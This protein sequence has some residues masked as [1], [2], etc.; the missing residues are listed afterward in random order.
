MPSI[1]PPAA[2]PGILQ[3]GTARPRATRRGWGAALGTLALLAPDAARAQR[4]CADLMAL[5]RPDLRITRS[6]ALPAGTLPAENPGRAALTG[7]ARS[8]AALPA[9]CVVEGMIAPRTAADG[10]FFGI[11]FQ[12]RLPEAWNGRFLF[13]GGGGMDGVVSEAIGAIPVAGATGVPALNRGYAVV[14][15]DSGHQGRDASDAS[16]G[17]DQ[18]A[19]LDHAG[20]SIGPV[21][22]EA[23]ALIAARYG[24]GPDHAYFMGCSNGGRSAMMAAQRFPLEFDG[25]VA[26]NPGFRLSR[27]AIAQAWDVKALTAAAPRNEA[28]QPVLAA[29]LTPA[30]MTLLAEGIA[31]ACDA[32]DGLADGTVEAMSACRFDPATLRCPG[33]KAA[34]CLSDPQLRALERVFGGA[35]DSQ[36]RPLYAGWPWDPGIA[37]PG[38]RAWKLGT[39]TGGTPNARNAT[40][41]AASLGLYFMTPPVDGLDLRSFDFDRDPPRTAQTAAINDATATFLNSFS[42]H[43]GRLLVFHGQA[44]PVF[45]A[46]DLR[47][48]WAELARD[49]GGA[50]ALSAWARLFVVPGMNHCGGGPA[51]DDFDPLAAIEA[52]VERGQAPDRLLARGSAFPG[53][54][55]PLCPAPQEARYRGGDPQEAASF[56]CEAPAAP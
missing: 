37:A 30:D 48:H 29:A 32:A 56:A 6:E 3:P 28:G 27:A 55:R 42:G 35:R 18:Q 15:T 7:A 16:F 43:G 34:G 9:H 51:M 25:I 49:N 13:Q 4:A 54:S 26:G 22:R 11:G 24:R 17:T 19:R 31:K 44:D 1:R 8:R 50:E 53:R 40:L 21:A 33:E 12:L 14:S 23:R 47:D 20:G 52:W 45:S 46:T 36:D 38:W 39:A 2:R 5:A 10:R 41:A